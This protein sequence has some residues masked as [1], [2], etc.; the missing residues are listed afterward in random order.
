MKQAAKRIK[1]AP[2]KRRIL[3]VGVTVAMCVLA[4]VSAAFVLRS[5][6]PVK[7]FVLSGVTQYDR[8][9]IAGAS[10]IK[11]GDKLY[12]IDVDEA[13]RR[14]L[15]ECPYLESVEIKRKF[16][17][18]VVFRV[19]ERTPMWYVDVAGDYYALDHTMLVIE[20]SVSKDKY[21]NGGVAQLV[22]PNLRVVMCGAL[23]E[24]GKDETEITKAL[25]LISAVQSDPL[26]PRITL[27]DMESR[28]D[29]YIVIDGK[30]NV[31]MGDTANVTAKL[32]A[33]REI[34]NSGDLD[35][36]V[37]ADIDASNPATISVR[38]IYS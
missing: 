29:V 23:P 28:F 15:D 21:V 2:D 11:L 12:S 35:G 24:F 17:G 19:V 5:F 33:M 22:M 38:P 18:T 16:P 25:E 30:Y 32:S 3:L 34:I 36:Y 9:A 6:L 13:E 27:V 37:G 8:S 1:K 10:G 14:M 20:E 26:K 31:Y 7:E 4:L